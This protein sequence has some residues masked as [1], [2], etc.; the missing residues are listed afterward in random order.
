MYLRQRHTRARQAARTG[1]LQLDMLPTCAYIADQHPETGPIIEADSR[2]TTLLGGDGARPPATFAATYTDDCLARMRMLPQAAV[3]Y[4]QFGTWCAERTIMTADGDPCDVLMRAHA[5]A[6]TGRW[7]VLVIDV[8]EQTRAAEIVKQR[9]GTL[10]REVVLHNASLETARRETEQ[11]HVEQTILNAMIARLLAE[12]LSEDMA[13]R[14]IGQAAQA[15][16]PSSMGN[17]YLS[18]GS[19]LLTPVAPWVR[20]DGIPAG[21][22]LRPP[23]RLSDIPT[24][25]QRESITVGERPCSALLLPILG[26]RHI[27]GALY[28]VGAC[29]DWPLAD[30]TI[31]QFGRLIG[32]AIELVRATMLLEDQAQ[33]D[34]L[35]DV[36]N[37][38][39]LSAAL[40]PAIARASNGGTSVAVVFVDIDH[41]K[42]INDTY[43]HAIG[44]Q[45]L[46]QV[47][48]LLKK[49][50]RDGDMVAR[51]GGDE[52]VLVL[53][54][55]DRQKAI[56]RIQAMHRQAAALDV[57]ANDNTPVP[58]SLSIGVAFGPQHGKDAVTLRRVADQAMYEAKQGGRNQVV[59]VRD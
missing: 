36:Y 45:A 43:G 46:R 55:A 49:L 34:P 56:G 30:A 23:A 48:A 3:R 31:T 24:H 53:P 6:Q 20:P 11:R 15:L 58:I 7:I 38:R 8:T 14:A 33:R 35:T 28:A 16:L 2:L 39:Y 41:F 25:L 50:V 52:F 1:A 12:R 5:D 42:T 47:A 27:L 4:D 37:R 13:Y 22:L 26:K 32:I 9:A 54:C 44:D 17:L 51:W 57:L 21:G 18:D 29:A 40:E 59:V 10:A 19:P